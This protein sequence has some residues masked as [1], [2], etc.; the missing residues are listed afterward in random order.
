MSLERTRTVLVGT[1]HP[2]NIGAAARAM[3]TMGLSRLYLVDPQCEPHDPE[4]VARAAGALEVL[5]QARRCPDLDTALRGCRLAFGL[6]AR[7]RAERHPQQ[8]LRPAAEAAAAEGGTEELAWVFGRER[9]GLTNTELDRCH[10]L[11]RIPA[12]PGYSSLNL[13]QSVQ[14]VAWELRMAGAGQ[15]ALEQVEAADP[16]ASLDTLERFFAHLKEVAGQVGFL[17]RHNPE[18]TMRRLRNLFR[19]ARPTENEVRMLRG[20]LSHILDSRRWRS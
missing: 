20:L 4:A 8:M 15:A 18:L 11:V 5:E 9:T 13:A 3:R 6:S 12:D 19:R 14:L 17:D 10:Y 2:G 1:S 7:D 16:P